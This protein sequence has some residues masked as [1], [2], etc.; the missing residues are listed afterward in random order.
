MYTAL[1]HSYTSSELGTAGKLGKALED[2]QQA[3]VQ[4]D[5][6]AVECMLE[7]LAVHPDSFLRTDILEYMRERWI[8]LSPRGHNFVVAGLLRERCFEQALERLEYMV[9]EKLRI[10]EWL[11]DKTMWML[12]EFGE[13]EEAFNVLNLRQS[14]QGENAR[15]SPSLYT[16]LLDLAG[17][18][19]IVSLSRVPYGFHLTH[20]STK[21]Q[22]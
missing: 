19:H 15:V 14:V 11:W 1:I 4:L 3:G 18:K 13:V 17:K 6:R 8:N 21:L 16:Q 5:D 20:H 10:E 22:V 7:A 12:L 2:M 9:M